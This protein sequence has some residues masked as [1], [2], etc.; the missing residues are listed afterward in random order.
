MVVPTTLQFLKMNSLQV[1][2]SRWTAT[3]TAVPNRSAGK[4]QSAGRQNQNKR[5]NNS[6]STNS[7]DCSK[8]PSVSSSIK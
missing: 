1:H 4:T 3:R 8:N 2:H 7:C 5:F 6:S